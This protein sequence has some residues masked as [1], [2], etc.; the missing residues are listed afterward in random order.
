MF[1]LIEDRRFDTV[2]VRIENREF[3]V[4]A[5]ISVAAAV[6]LCGF[7]KVRNT[8]V[9]TSPRLPY[10]MMGICFDCL[11]QIDGVANQ[12]ACQI[13]VRENMTIE[14]QLGAAELELPE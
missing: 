3:Q 11:M 9:S 14:Y 10:C 6:L 1:R 7:K 8:P 5:G 4:P 12:Q 13:E 2:S